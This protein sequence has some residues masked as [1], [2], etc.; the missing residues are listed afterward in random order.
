MGVPERDEEEEEVCVFDQHNCDPLSK[1]TSKTYLSIRT[2]CE[3]VAVVTFAEQHNR[4]SNF[5]ILT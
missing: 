3:K 2:E 1:L 5:T 4:N